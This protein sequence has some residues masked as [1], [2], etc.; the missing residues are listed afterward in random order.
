MLLAPLAPNHRRNGDTRMATDDVTKRCSCCQQQLPIDQF[1]KQ[2]LGKYGVTSMCKS[3]TSEHEKNRSNSYIHDPNTPIPVKICSSCQQEKPINQ[4][5]KLKH[6]KYGVHTIC[7]E[8]TCREHKERHFTFDPEKFGKN[9]TCSAC[10]ESKH[11]SMF[12]NSKTNPNG[13]SY[14]CKDCYSYINS[15]RRNV[16]EENYEKKLRLC[17]TCR[18]EKLGSEFGKHKNGKGDYVTDVKNVLAVLEEKIQEQLM[19]A[20]LAATPLN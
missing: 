1:H 8:C 12:S 10:K 9:I 20:S 16:P 15:Q 7:K 13:K 3:C 17:L 18:E 6:G 14:I 11:Y 19:L 5:H 2:K 4:F